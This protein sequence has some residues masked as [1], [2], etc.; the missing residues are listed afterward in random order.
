VR[1]LQEVLR[2]VHS[3][4]Q[5]GGDKVT[6]RAWF[7]AF[8]E[9][10]NKT[11]GHGA[12]TP[13][14]CVKLAPFLD[15]S[16]R[17]LCKHN[18]IFARPW[19]YLHRNLSGKYNVMELG[20]DA[21]AFA[22]LKS[23]EAITGDNYPD[24]LYIVGVDLRRVELV[25]TDINASDF[26]LPNGA[27]N[28]KTFEL[29]SL[30]SDSRLDGD[31]GPYLAV[32]GERPPS[33]THGGTKLDIAG[34]VFTNLP[35]VPAGYVHRSRLED[36]VRKAL[37]NDRHPIVT[38][39][40]RGGIG[41]TSLALSVLH[42]IT[43][44]DRY[45]M[46]LW[47]SARDI[48][49]SITGPKVVQPQVLTE[50]DI[51]DD[52][53]TLIGAS[54]DGANGQKSAVAAMA[55]HLQ[56]SALGP[57]LFVFD[58]F[59]TVRSPVDLFQWIDTNIRVPNKAMITSRFRDF[60]ADYPIE[61]SGMER[62]EAE[63][64]IRQTAALLQVEYLITPKYRDQIFEESDGHP[65]VIK[66]ILGEVADSKTLSKPRNLIAWKDEILDALFERTFATLSPV[67]SRI[68]LTLSGWRS[69][70]PQLAL[71]AVLLRHPIEGGDP[72][73]GINELLRMSLI[74]RTP[75]PDGADFLH[76]PLTAALFG[77]KKLGV[78]PTRI[79]IKNDIK[80][81]QE[82]G[83]TALGSLKEGI[84][85]RIRSL[86]RLVAKRIGQNMSAFDDMRPVL[87]FVARSYA[88]A[89]L[90]LADL[91]DEDQGVTGRSQAAE[92]V[93]RF[94]EQ[95]PPPHEA[96]A[97]WERLSLLY[98]AANDVLGASNA[99]LNAAETSVPPLHAVSNMANWLNNE[100]DIIETMD[101]GERGTVFRPM[102]Q[103]LERHIAE[104]SATDLS[105]LAW[106]HLHSGNDHRAR[107]VADLGLQR[108][109]D[110]VYC[111]RLVD[112][113]AENA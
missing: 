46:I 77:S 16:I 58:N 11:R 107:D 66:I 83:P 3:S 78:S 1:E 44:T 5:T 38:L 26:Y 33:E 95:Q 102:A 42:E 63:M 43:G 28:G 87:E 73:A 54:A 84:G 45:D 94:L 60:K 97:A 6:L 21:T 49:L 7:S 53:K 69:L 12:I 8:A 30:I 81:L 41:K 101:V 88:P 39:V 72:T 105:R 92:Y 82:I 96:Q 59:E 61:V 14:V 24:G 17:L 10:R 65:Y 90:M 55:E 19:A 4:A 68:F 76:V 86:F 31:G 98:R 57:I 56:K 2:G 29:H 23:A 36:D 111:Q 103:L 100:R 104:A 99:F 37:L 40:G 13:A 20:G 93:R 85:P 80:F 112:R 15:R 74:E 48:D 52:F 89:W 50:R 109:P 79:L 62:I 25:H 18:P 47:F 75:A 9:V 110:N 32:A 91:R 34:N 67:A 70:V 22:K 108:D 106:L 51:A 27:F 35:A 64:L 71:E 113:L